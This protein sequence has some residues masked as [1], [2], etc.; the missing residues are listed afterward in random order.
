VVVEKSNYTLIQLIG[1]SYIELLRIRPLL[2]YNSTDEIYARL[3]CAYYQNDHHKIDRIFNQVQD[4]LPIDIRDFFNEFIIFR[5][6]MIL[7]D[8]SKEQILNLTIY[9]DPTWLGEVNFCAGLGAYKIK[10]FKIAKELFIKSSNTLRSQGIEKKSL[11]ARLN[12][13]TME[14]N[15]DNRNK[16]ICAYLKY[17]CEC[18]SCG[19]VDTIANAYLNIADEFYK[20]GA[21]NTAFE[22]CTKSLEQLRNQ[23]NTHQEGEAHALK[24]EIL[25]GL[26]RKKE[27]KEMMCE[28]KRD[29]STE[30][31]EALKVIELRHFEGNSSEID[32]DQL[33]PPWKAKVKG[34]L[35]ISKLG[36]LEDQAVA[37]LG[38]G[39][40]KLNDLAMT[41]YPGV[42]EG[43]SHNR[44][45]TLFT[46]INKK[47]DNLIIYNSKSGMYE[48]SY[49]RPLMEINI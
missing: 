2:N 6:D 12:A 20:M 8:L 47:V 23:R 45:T 46:R 15:I 27:A 44:V 35:N 25:C 9:I 5:R 1:C 28:L 30:L 41:L 19:A 21:F 24:I 49:N 11:L 33:S 36:P 34:Y 37:L 48:L 26:D 14:G 3:M 16:L 13:I 10:E 17:I 29:M 40:V 39:E 32:I 4:V 38:A 31:I 7:G 42:D 18:I 22:F 43:D